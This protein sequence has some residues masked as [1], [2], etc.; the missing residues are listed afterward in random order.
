MPELARLL[1]QRRHQLRIGVAKGIDRDAG[2]EIQISPPI[3][4][5]K[6]GA[7]APDERDIRPVVGGK[8]SRKH[9]KL[10]LQPGKLSRGLSA[11]YGVF[12]T[13]APSWQP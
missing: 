1:G 2:A 9:G 6:V 3:L 12:A 10:L 7:F 11:F 13:P 5:E 8:Q 4:G